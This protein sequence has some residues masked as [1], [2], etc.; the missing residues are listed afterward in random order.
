MRRPSLANASLVIAASYVVSNL[1]GF[2]ARA[3][4]N[5]RFGAGIEQD[6][7]RAAFNIPDLL[8]NLLAGG[9]LASA[10]IPTYTGRLAKG[11]RGL[12]WQ[13]ARRVALLVFVV[14]GVLA[15]LATVFAP[16]LIAQFIA[17]GL[18]AEGQRLTASLMRIMLLSTVIFS[19]SGLLM[20][21][22]QSNGRFLAPAI[23]PVLYNLGQIVGALLLTQSFGIHGL[24]Y[25]VVLGALAHLLVQIPALG[26]EVRVLSAEAD[27]S[28]QH[29]ST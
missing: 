27:S 15:A 26:A 10:F 8:F 20:G 4:I 2:L 16:V 6:A 12:A 19:V 1:A 21:I 18:P 17:P 5:A 11:E 3:L 13:L 9:A 22:L 23:A 24:A 25:G 7:F 28:T 14:I 29:S